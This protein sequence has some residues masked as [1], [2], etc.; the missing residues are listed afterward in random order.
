[1]LVDRSPRSM[2]ELVVLIGPDDTD[3]QSTGVKLYHQH[4]PH[5]DALGYIDW[6]RETETIAKGE[7]FEEIH[8]FVAVLADNQDALPATWP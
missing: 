2:D 1:M 4:L 6:D 7:R 5:L 8:A 3:S